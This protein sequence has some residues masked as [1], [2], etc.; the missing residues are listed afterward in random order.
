MT[1]HFTWFIPLL[2]PNFLVWHNGKKPVMFSSPDPPVPLSWWRDQP[3][4]IFWNE[5]S[6]Q[7][8]YQ[9]KIAYQVNFPYAKSSPAKRD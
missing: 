9:V 5:T 7:F 3:V 6:V 4:D 1:L 8:A 2:I